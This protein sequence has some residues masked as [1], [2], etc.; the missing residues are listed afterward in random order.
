MELQAQVSFGNGLGMIF[1]DVHGHDVVYL[2]N[3]AVADH[4]NGE[5]VPFFSIELSLVPDGSEN[6][7]VLVSLGVG[8]LPTFGNDAALSE[9]LSIE[10][11]E[12][13]L[14]RVQVSLI[15]SQNEILQ[16][17]HGLTAVLYTRVVSLEFDHTG[18]FEVLNHTTLPNKKGVP[19]GWV[20]FGRFSYDRAVF[21][22][23]ELLLAHPTVE[24]LAVE[25]ALEFL[26]GQRGQ[27]ECQ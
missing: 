12:K 19:L 26:S 9:F 6:F 14:F 4:Q 18:E 10:H 5:L 20:F 23:P 27:T 13:V 1:G 17:A 16:V 15:A 24:V 2:V 25:E 8:F 3:Q 11:A 21:D 22:L 7:D